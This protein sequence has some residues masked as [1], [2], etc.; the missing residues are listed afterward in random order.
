[1]VWFSRSKEGFLKKFLE[2][3]NGIP[4]KDTINRVFSAINSEHF[5][6]CFIEWVNSIANLSDGAVVAIEGKTLK[7]AKSHGK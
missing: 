3:P 6:S 7:G 5:E 2:S 1:M 4:S